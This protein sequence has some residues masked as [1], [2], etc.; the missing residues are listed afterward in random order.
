MTEPGSSPSRRL[1]L[2]PD[3]REILKTLRR[4][5]CRL[6][7][8][9]NTG[10]EPA[11]TIDA[12][13]RNAGILTHFEP[14]LRLYSSEV[15]M[16][17]DS[18]KI[19]KL[20]AQRAGLKATPSRCL[21]VGEE[22]RER[23]FAL[24][25]G[26]RVAPAVSLAL[27]ALEERKIQFLRIHVPSHQNQP[28]WRRTLQQRT[29][30]LA[31]LH[32][33]GPDGRDIYVMASLETAASLDNQGFHVDRLG[34]VGA[35]D[36]GDLYL[37]RDDR[38]TRTGFL[39]P[40]GQSET[41]LESRPD[42]PDVVS[43]TQ[44]GLFVIL[45]GTRNIE[46]LHFREARH[47]HTVKL[48][49][50][51][52]LLRPFSRQ[53]GFRALNWT[54]DAGAADRALTRHEIDALAKIDG[55]LIQ[56]LVDRYSGAT[57]I[58]GS[59]RIRS[60]H[61]QHPDNGLAVT[62]ILEDLRLL[63]GG[64]FVLRTHRIEGG[65][66]KNVEAEFRG[67]TQELVLITAHLDSTAKGDGTYRPDKDPAPGADDDASGIAAVLAAASVLARLA[68]GTK[69]RRTVRL[70]L[71]NAEEVGLVG[72]NHY[73]RALASQQAPVVAVFQMDMVGHRLAGSRAPHPFEIHLGYDSLPDTVQRSR[74]LAER[75]ERIIAQVAPNLAKPQIYDRNDP[76][77]G[78]SDHS[79]FQQRGYAAVC[80]S[81]DFFVGPDSAAPNPQPNPHYHKKTDQIIAPEYAAEVARAVAAAAWLTAQP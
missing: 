1:I 68:Q 72:S 10:Q 60:R 38:Q 41:L 48:L 44:E 14:K 29:R 39:S 18:P 4:K 51:P 45:P 35:P 55:A 75:M 22:A 50:D 53:P 28:V 70:V 76:A 57:P 20:A 16:E 7:V 69:P 59:R 17:K 77:S 19:F 49:P 54:A 26:W 52:S 78:R 31:P 43:S 40:E 23:T 58:D 66:I 2:F 8:I 37:L 81:E 79:S 12:M 42:R 33:A 32:V 15:R 5:G 6:G 65:R 21:F 73:A 11:A 67:R 46:E 34:P 80:V 64:Q 63:G 56:R 9:S 13:L 27:E 61:V 47:G 3:V 24:A 30:P 36:T 71:F 25:A 62:T 74:I